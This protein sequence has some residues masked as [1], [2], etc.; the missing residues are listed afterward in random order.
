MSGQWALLASKFSPSSYCFVTRQERCWLKSLTKFLTTSYRYYYNNLPPYSFAWSDNL[1]EKNAKQRKLN[2]TF[3]HAF[4]TINAW[5]FHA[6]VRKLV[7][8]CCKLHKIKCCVIWRQCLPY[9]LANQWFTSTYYEKIFML[10]W[11]F[12]YRLTYFTTRVKYAN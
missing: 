9:S 5:I 12:R 8:A 11:D 10:K 1:C 6:I 2:L 3:K 7:K 4:F